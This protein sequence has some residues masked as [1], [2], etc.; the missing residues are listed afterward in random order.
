MCDFSYLETQEPTPD[1][2][3]MQYGVAVTGIRETPG[4]P[5]TDAAA[6]GRLLGTTLHRALR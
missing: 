1:A 4:A 3:K 6:L 2:K 5:G